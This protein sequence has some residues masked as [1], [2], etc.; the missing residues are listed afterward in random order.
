RSICRNRLVPPDRSFIVHAKR[1]LAYHPH[2][3]L[4]YL[5]PC[6]RQHFSVVLHD[7]KGFLYDLIFHATCPYQAGFPANFDHRF[8]IRVY[9]V[10][11]HWAHDLPCK[12]RH[13]I[14]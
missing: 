10:N 2:D 11:V 8:S 12:S 4:M 3:G 13:E 14:H 7:D 1:C 9:N 6:F 5:L